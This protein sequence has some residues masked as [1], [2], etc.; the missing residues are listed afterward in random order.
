MLD[1][2]KAKKL[3][4]WKPVLTIDEAIKYTVDWYKTF[5]A[6]YYFCVRQINDYTD[7]AIERRS[8]GGNER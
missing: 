4:D 5:K 8:S 2:S 6:D 1:I 3:L 7:K